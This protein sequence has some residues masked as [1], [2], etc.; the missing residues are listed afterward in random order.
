[1][2]TPMRTPY[3]L[4]GLSLL[5]AAAGPALAD[6]C[7]MVP[8]IYTGDGPAITRIGAQKTYVFYK[9]GYESIALRPGFSGKVEEFGMLIPFPTPP[10]IR[11]VPDDVFAHVAAA[12]DP[13]ELTVHLWDWEEEA[14]MDGAGGAPNEGG[15]ERS[16]GVNEV[17]VLRQEAIG[18]YEVVVLEAGSSAAL[19][20]WMDD[21]GFVYPDGMDAPVQDYVEARWCFVAVKTRVAPKS[22]ADPQPGMREADPRLPA[23]ASFDGN[24][25][26]M[27]FRFRTDE[28]VVPMRLSA[29][30]AGELH[31]IVYCLADQPLRID[32]IPEALVTRQ[33]PGAELLRNVTGPLPVRFYGPEENLKDPERIRQ[34]LSYLNRDPVPHN[35]YA[36][37]LFAG[38]LLAVR[39]ERLSL[40]HEERE[41]ELLEIAERFGLRGEEIDALHVD[42]LREAYQATVLEA[43]ED[44]RGMTMTVIEGDFPREVLASANL[45]FSPYTRPATPRPQ[46]DQDSLPEYERSI[47]VRGGGLGDDG[48][49]DGRKAPQDEGDK[50]PREATSDAGEPEPSAPAGAKAPSSAPESPAAASAGCALTPRG[51]SPGPWALLLLVTLLGVG[52]RS[53]PPPAGC[54][55]R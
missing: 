15:V 23:G 11:K 50:A 51:G 9:D 19:N 25:Q 8:P 36:R 17:R 12:I 37:D 29:F 41:K 45:T 14:M 26:A 38:D 7:G 34:E 21:H 30:N 33:I 54:I 52:R 31:N 2:R 27:G 35:G 24:V 10:A 43:L 13:P 3:L 47:V 48:R 44:L 22:D 1:M 42:A 32:D 40:E 53:S 4:S 39:T 28:L 49:D 16:L 20:V 5:L 46:V 55:S 18:M 6:P